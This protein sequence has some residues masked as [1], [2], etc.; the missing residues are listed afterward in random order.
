VFDLAA[1]TTVAH[2]CRTFGVHRSTYYRWK[3]AAARAL[4]SVQVARN[5]GSAPESGAV[6][7]LDHDPVA[8]PRHA[9][10][11]RASRLQQVPTSRPRGA[12]GLYCYWRTGSTVQ[13][14]N[15]VRVLAP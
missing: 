12:R 13:V 11:Y 3:R 2:A 10:R 15:A 5:P 7:Q 1:R 14:P 6:Q 8:Q 9:A 4:V